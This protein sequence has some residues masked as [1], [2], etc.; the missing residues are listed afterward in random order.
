MNHREDVYDDEHEA[1]VKDVQHC[2]VGEDEAVVA[3]LVLDDPDNVS[4]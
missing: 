4:N 3:L 1:A 2:F